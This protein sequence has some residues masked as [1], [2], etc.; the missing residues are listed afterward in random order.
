MDIRIEV[1]NALHRRLAIPRHSVTA[2]VDG[3]LE[4]L[5]RVLDRA[6]QK[7]CAEAIARRVPGVIDV[8]NKIAIRASVEFGRPTLHP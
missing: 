1:A 8:K 4:T 7:S 3:G 5:H 6:Y 2:E